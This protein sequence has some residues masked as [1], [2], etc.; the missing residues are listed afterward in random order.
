M[1][2]HPSDSKAA[3]EAI[4]QRYDTN[5]DHRLSPEEVQAIIKE[6]ETKR[7]SIPAPVLEALKLYDSNA[8]GTLDA[9]V[10]VR[11]MFEC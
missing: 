1:S 7:D 8:D 11:A 4:L 6:Y 5:K 10:G 2:S 9:V 3:V